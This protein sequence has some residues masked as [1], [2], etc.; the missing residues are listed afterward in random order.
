[1]HA[2][3]INLREG[4]KNG[5][6]WRMAVVIAHMDDGPEP[7]NLFLNEKDPQVKQGDVLDMTPRFYVDRGG[8]IAVSFK[9]SL[10][11]KAS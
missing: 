6:H 4:D 8:K 2:Q 9:L 7:L 3:V 5:K 1:M 11:S 10:K